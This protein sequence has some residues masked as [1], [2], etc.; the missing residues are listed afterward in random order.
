MS[1]LSAS[2][3]STYMR[4]HA[5]RDLLLDGGLESV[6]TYI[7]SGNI[8][9]QA[10]EGDERALEERIRSLIR[11]RYDFDVPTMV[12]QP[13]EFKAIL[14]GNPHLKDSTKPTD[15][16]Y[17]TFLDHNPDSDRIEALKQFDYRPEEYVIRDRVVFFYSPNGY[18][19]AKM[20]NN[21]FEQKLKMPATTRN[22]KTVNVLYEMASGT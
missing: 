15:R 11:E 1:P 5:L 21:F 13:K 14:E 7:Q 12:R 16:M 3:C 9:F 4:S 19:K 17:V 22:W 6:Q 8:V 20:N 2:V 18:G 10:S